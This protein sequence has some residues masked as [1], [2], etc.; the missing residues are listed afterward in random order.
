[1]PLF[2]D[3]VCEKAIK[4]FKRS[5]LYTHYSTLNPDEPCSL[6]TGT[7][8]AT[9]ST[10]TKVET[11]HFNTSQGKCQ[12]SHIRSS[13]ILVTAQRGADTHTSHNL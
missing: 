6:A 1:M 10:Q 11:S 8:T 5:A 13:A 4:A 2:I 9:Y 12:L 7:G 3:I